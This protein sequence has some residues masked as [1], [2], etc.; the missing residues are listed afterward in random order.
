MKP[1]T[2]R[3]AL[4]TGA[5]GG[6]GQP[7]AAALAQAGAAVAIH[8]GHHVDGARQALA[9]I[10]AQGGQGMVVSA[11]IQHETAVRSMVDQVVARY[12]R[13]DILVNNA[14]ITRDGLLIQMAQDAWDEVINTNLR[15][16]FYCAKY[17]LRAMLRQKSGTVINV[18]SISGLLG[19]AGQANYA[20]AKA[21]LI[22][23]TLAIAQEYA[24]RG[25]TAN[26]VVPGIIDT[27]MSRA[28]TSRV[29]DRKLEAILLRRPGTPDE[30][31]QAIV[32]LAQNPYIN[33]TVLRVDGGIRF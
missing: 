10:E 1:L 31:A 19:N 23:L 4:V 11:N 6:L 30:V 32:L 7:I 21:G 16:A 5:S 29:V 3:V 22:G 12:Q 9:A 24:A 27:P 20:A 33:G 28:V 18:S 2:G 15:G 25:I 14:G 26:A 8:Y 17:A 13:L